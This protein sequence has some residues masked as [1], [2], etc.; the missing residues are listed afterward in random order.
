MANLPFIPLAEALSALRQYR[1][2]LKERLGA[3][4]A[5]R[6]GQPPRPYYVDAMFDC[7]ERMIQ[8]EMT[9]I[10]RFTARLETGQKEARDGQG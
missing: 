6:A 7:S 5:R 9:W 10:A 3:L 2:T 8:A 1:G 4:R